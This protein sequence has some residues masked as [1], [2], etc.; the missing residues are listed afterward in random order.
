[1]LV[2]SALDEGIALAARVVDMMLYDVPNLRLGSV[3]V[4]IHSTFTG[5]DGAPVQRPILTTTAERSIADAIDWDELTAAEVLGRFETRYSRAESGQA[6]PIEL[7]PVQGG[8]P[9]EPEGAA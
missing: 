9:G 4:D 2:A 5:T 6:L 8:L 7:D 1:V 3:R